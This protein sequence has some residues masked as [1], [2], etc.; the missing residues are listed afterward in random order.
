MLHIWQDVSIHRLLHNEGP[1]NSAASNNKDLLLFMGLWF[2]WAVLPLLTGITHASAVGP[3]GSSPDFGQALSR[4]QLLMTVGWSGWPQL[5]HLGSPPCDLSCFIGLLCYCLHGDARVS[6][7]RKRAR[8][9]EAKVQNQYTVTSATLCW[10]KHF[11]K[12]TQIPRMGT[13]TPLDRGNCKATSQRTYSL[14][15]PIAVV[16]KFQ[17]ASES[18]GRLVKT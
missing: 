2:S 5:E 7:E 4:V 15:K 12:L 13:E 14:L 10:S 9:L 3:G 11:S 6:R 16:A 8:I 17:H 18:H 1:R